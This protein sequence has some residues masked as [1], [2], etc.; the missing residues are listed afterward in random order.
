[1]RARYPGQAYLDPGNIW[2]DLTAY[3]GAPARATPKTA[4]RAGYEQGRLLGGGSAINAM[5]A[6]RGAP[7]D[8]DEWGALGA[9][10]WSWDKRAALFQEARGATSTSTSPITARPARSRSPHQARPHVAVRQGA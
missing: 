7:S 1:V 6:N 4:S 9:E 8:Y 10:G 5:V 2:P 3:M